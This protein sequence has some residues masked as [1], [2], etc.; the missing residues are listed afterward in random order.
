MSADLVAID[1]SWGGLD[2]FRE[3]LRDLPADLDAAVVI[4]QHRSPEST[5]SPPR[6]VGRRGPPV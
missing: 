5:A 6:P 2:T 1:A 3:L 4:A